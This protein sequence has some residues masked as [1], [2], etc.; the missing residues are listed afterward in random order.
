MKSIRRFFGFALIVFS[1]LG[2]VVSITG[3]LALPKFSRQVRVG[4]EE[5]LDLS[6]LTLG[7]TDESLALAGTSI[8]Q[9]IAALDSVRET[10]LGIGQTLDN[11]DPLLD[12]VGD[13]VGQELP[14][15][16]ESTQASL[17]ASEA[18]ARVIDQVLYGLNTVTILTGIEY[19][20]GCHTRASGYCF[21]IRDAIG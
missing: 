1:T 4:I 8:T 3:L 2:L 12:S 20:P 18:S 7:T 11:T 6:L 19:D 14:D 16:V 21:G 10:T 15:I 13:I 5:G 9:A 17:A